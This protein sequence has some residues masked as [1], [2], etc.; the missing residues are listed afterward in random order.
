MDHNHHCRMTALL[1]A[2]HDQDPKVLCDGSQPKEGGVVHQVPISIR[3]RSLTGEPSL[4]DTLFR[5]IAIAWKRPV[6]SRA[7]QNQSSRSTM[8][9]PWSFPPQ[10]LLLIA[11]LVTGRPALA[12][13]PPTPAA[14]SRPPAAHPATPSLLIQ[15][16][17]IGSI[18]LGQTLQQARQAWPGAR[19][20]RSSDG[21]G[22]ALVAVSLGPDTV[23][24]LYAKERDRAAP[25]HWSAVIE[26][27]ETFS[28]KPA[29]AEGIR[30]GLPIRQ[31]EQV[32]GP[33]RSIVRSE[34]EERELI[35]FS[36]QPPQ[37]RFRL[38]PG[39]M[40]PGPNNGTPTYRPEARLLSIAVTNR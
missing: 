39:S 2:S 13:P 25:I 28:P 12:Q 22:I 31:L 10:R 16:R 40:V 26:W 36:R 17:G 11:A 15:G 35:T 4:S 23:L 37:L 18:R 9:S 7:E 8:A 21:E 19:F 5:K 1:W 6:G 20:Q 14:S 33:V 34:V 30:V 27:I 3:L 29:T 38:T 32:Y 24:Q